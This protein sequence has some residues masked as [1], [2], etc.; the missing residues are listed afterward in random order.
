MPSCTR[1]GRR[2]R[3]PP[4][5]EQLGCTERSILA[6]DE[7]WAAQLAIL[8]LQVG[9]VL[10]QHV[11]AGRVVQL[12]GHVQGRLLALRTRAHR[13][14]AYGRGR[15]ASWAEPQGADKAASREAGRSDGTHSANSV[16]IGTIFDQ[17]L[18]LLGV[19]SAKRGEDRHH[20]QQEGLVQSILR[21]FWYVC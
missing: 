20:T 6:G 19:P 12:A 9:A 16:H 10:E 15:G 4:V 2:Q 11:D 5:D 1:Y 8:G 7:Q 21:R 17:F 13:G 18:Q 14:S 3:R